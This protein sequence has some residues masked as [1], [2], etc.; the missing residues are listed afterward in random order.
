ML[1]LILGTNDPN[2]R[3]DIQSISITP[4]QSATIKYTLISLSGL[5]PQEIVIDG[6]QYA[7]WGTDDTI[8]YHIVCARHKLEYVPYVE[9]QFYEEVFVYKNDQGL[10]VTENIQKP[11]PNYV[12]GSN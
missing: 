2:V 3:I 10:L 11:N 9:P 5:Q 7:Q 8:I 1:K 6:E 12:S 4:T